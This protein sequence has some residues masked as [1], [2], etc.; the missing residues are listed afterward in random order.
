MTFARYNLTRW[1]FL[2]P[3][4]WLMMSCAAFLALFQLIFKPHYWEKTKHGLH[5]HKA[6]LSPDHKATPSS[7][8]TV[9]EVREETLQ[10]PALPRVYTGAISETVPTPPPKHSALSHWLK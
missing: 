7:H 1:A 10:L 4:Y 5:L 6:H 2:I 8:V 3:I 9:E